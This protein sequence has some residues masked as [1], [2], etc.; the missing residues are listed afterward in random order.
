MINSITKSKRIIGKKAVKDVKGT[1]RVFY[2]IAS[3]SV[4]ELRNLTFKKVSWFSNQSLGFT[5]SGDKICKA[6]TNGFDKNHTFDP[7]KKINRVEVI[8]DKEELEIIQI[9]FFSGEE[10][11]VKVG[12]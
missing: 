2:E 4:E 8:I 9:H 1:S 11:L 7:K 10:R 12:V 6:G 5:L 3:V